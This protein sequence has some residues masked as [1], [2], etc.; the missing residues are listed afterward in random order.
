MTRSLDFN[1]DFTC[2]HC[3][4]H[5]S[6]SFRLAGVQNRNHCPYCLWSRHMDLFEAGD[7]LSACKSAMEPIGLT[8][9][10]CRKKYS[11]AMGG[12]LM[13]IHCCTACDRVSINRIAA[14]DEAEKIMLVFYRSFE[15]PYQL[16]NVSSM[17]E[18]VFLGQD[19]INQVSHMLYGRHFQPIPII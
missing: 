1:Q 3:G 4:Q 10:R 16:P 19:H 7:R 17:G 13:L 9:K 2:L 6:S 11:S 18:I 5:I 12:E 15:L 14:D 8:L